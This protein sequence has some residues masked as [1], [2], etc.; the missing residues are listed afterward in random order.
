MN[1]TNDRSINYIY[2]HI[3]NVIKNYVF[4]FFHN[5]IIIKTKYYYELSKLHDSGDIHITHTKLK[6]HALDLI[7]LD[8]IYLK[9]IIT[10]VYD[11]L[12]LQMNLFEKISIKL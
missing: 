7:K 3:K 9:I 2:C 8:L 11:E 1:W 6:S 4:V 5:Q 12:L 10:V